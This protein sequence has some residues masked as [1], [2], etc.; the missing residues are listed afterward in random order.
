MFAVF[1]AIATVFAARPALIA[2]E[3]IVS[4]VVMVAL[5]SQTKFPAHRR[6]S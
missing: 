6:V 3:P 4:S 2:V 5:W 1:A